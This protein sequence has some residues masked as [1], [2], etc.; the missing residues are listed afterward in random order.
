LIERDNT[1]WY[2]LG[3]VSLAMIGAAVYLLPLY[4]PPPSAAVVAPVVVGRDWSKL[5][6]IAGRDSCS[7]SIKAALAGRA[8]EQSADV[9]DALWG[10]AAAI[11]NSRNT[12][13]TTGTVRAANSLVGRI[14]FGPREPWAASVGQVVDTLLGATLGMED[15]AL[16]EAD[17][18]SLIDC[19]LAQAYG[20]QLAVEG[21]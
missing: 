17:R 12:P 9:R 19:L 10:L 5:S 14:V 20:A 6:P 16:T 2:V 7:Q 1:P 18:E 11:D 8:A 15:R 13:L 3:V 4:F 21:R